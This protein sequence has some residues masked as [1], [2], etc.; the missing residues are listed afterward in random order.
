MNTE[1]IKI[2]DNFV[3]MI[4]TLGDDVKLDIIAKIKASLTQSEKK[5]VDNSWKDLFGAF[6]SDQTAEEMINEI[7]SSRYTNRQ[8]EDI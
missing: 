1:N 5:P 4:K 7:R 3:D 6:K 2:A 8:I